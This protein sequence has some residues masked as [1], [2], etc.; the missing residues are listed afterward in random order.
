MSEKD[1]SNSCFDPMKYV[2]RLLQIWEGLEATWK[3]KCEQLHISTKLHIGSQK[4][5][6][7]QQDI[8]YAVLHSFRILYPAWP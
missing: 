7:T 4:S 2:W 3:E 6:I 1:G 5:E 8:K